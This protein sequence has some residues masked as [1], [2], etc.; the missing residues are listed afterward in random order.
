VRFFAFPPNTI[1]HKGHLKMKKSNLFSTAVIFTALIGLLLACNASTANMSSLT[2]SSDKEGKSAQTKFK[3][4]ETIYGSAQI[5][6]NPGKVKVKLSLADPK[7][8]TIKG[9][10]VSVDID[11]DRKAEYSLALPAGVAPGTYTLKADMI[12]EAGEKKDGKTTAVTI[13]A[14]AAPVAPKSETSKDD[15]D[16]KE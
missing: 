3:T 14:G 9:S 12:N 10:E 15:S 2:T 11:G 4:G 13:E 5:S 6:N 8:E 1:K 16:D 7:G